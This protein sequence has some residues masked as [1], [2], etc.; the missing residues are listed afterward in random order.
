MISLGTDD[1][2]DDMMN[3]SEFSDHPIPH[4][5][6][7]TNWDCGLACVAMTLKGL[8]F[9]CQLEDM[10]R[11]CPVNCVWTID[12]AFLLRNYVQDF[13][14]YTSYFGSRKEYQDQK[15]YQDNFSEDEKRVNRLFAIAKSRSVH[16]VRMM[17]P[18]DDFKRFLYCKKFAIITL[19]NARL[20]R[21][22][23]CR[24]HGGCLGSVCV[25]LDMLLERFKGNDYLGHFIVLIGYDPTEDLFI[26]RDPAVKDN[27]CTILASDLDDARQSE[28]TDN[29]CI[30]IQLS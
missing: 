13:T 11:Q 24:K 25:Q 5:L 12:L 20:L 19:V 21:C 29:D 14:Y 9:S 2:I 4:I 16:I 22:H 3:Y 15:F 28:G 23:L 8:G 1:G 10:S 18:L 7:D 26:Y 6:Q 27:F 17:L 30:V